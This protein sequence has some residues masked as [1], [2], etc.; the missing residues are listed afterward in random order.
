MMMFPL[1]GLRH[2]RDFYSRQPH[3]QGEPCTIVPEY[4]LSAE[5]RAMDGTKAC[6]VEK[7]SAAF[8][9]TRSLAAAW[10]H[11]HAAATR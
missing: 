11:G 7:G 9:R 4:V 6:F 2:P 8:E 10:R 1:F 3:P 5:I